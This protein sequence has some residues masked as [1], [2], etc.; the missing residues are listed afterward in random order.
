M[1]N[2]LEN[3]DGAQSPDRS[4]A[5]QIREIYG[6]DPE[7]AGMSESSIVE[8]IVAREANQS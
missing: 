8:C 7:L 3:I 5:E 4:T 2:K 1:N 6:S